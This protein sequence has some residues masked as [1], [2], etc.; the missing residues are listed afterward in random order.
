MKITKN[1]KLFY[2]AIFVI[3]AV[4]NAVVFIIPFN[5]GYGFWTGYGFSMLAMIITASV[6][7]YTFNKKELKSKFY[8]ISLVSVVTLY[9]VIQ[10]IV[11]LIEMGLDFIPVP[12]QYGFAVNI[13]LLGICLIGLFSVDAAKEEIERIDEK[14]KEKVFYIKSLQVDIETLVNKTTDDSVKKMLKDLS[15]TVKY[16]DPMSKPQLVAIENKIE[17]K[18]A[19]L[20][21]NIEYNDINASK[22]LCEELQQLFAE[23][24]KKIKILK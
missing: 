24:N 2:A 6:S 16:S 7:Y 1:K 18:T 5:R 10:L 14:I 21:K 17:N 3:L 15:E 19:E 4:Y 12:F 22:V 20:A 11:G 23:R 9:V 8:G 13:I